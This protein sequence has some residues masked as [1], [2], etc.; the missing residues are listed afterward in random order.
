MEKLL[1]GF[2]ILCS[3]FDH[4]LVKKGGNYLQVDIIRGRMINKEIRFIYPLED[5]LD[6]VNGKD[7]Y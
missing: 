6:Y 3:D 4:S 5:E 2:K 7:I 1:E